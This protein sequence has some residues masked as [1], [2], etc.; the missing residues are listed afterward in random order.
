MTGTIQIVVHYR[1]T[2]FQSLQVVKFKNSI[3]I[4]VNKLAVY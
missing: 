4:N 3:L 2:I 1:V